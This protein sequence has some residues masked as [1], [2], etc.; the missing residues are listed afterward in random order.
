MA[1]NSKI[2]LAFC[3]D[4]IFPYSIGGIQR[5]STLLLN[6]LM[7]YDELEIHVIHPHDIFV[8]KSDKIIEHR[9][10]PLDD[11]K[12]YL[13]ECY[14][15]S[16]RV[17]E[18]INKIQPNII[19]AQGLTVWKN[20]KKHKK[21]V[22]NNPHGLES[23]QAIGLKARLV[24]KLFMWVQK[25]IFK[26]SIY[27]ASEGG[28]LSEI[29]LSLGLKEKVV[30]LPNAVNLPDRIKKEFPKKLEPIK[31]FFMARFVKNKGIDVL[32]EAIQKLNEM[33]YSSKI[34]FRLGGKGALWDSINS[35]NKFFNVVLSGYL[36]DSELEEAYLN[37]DIFLLPTLFEGMPTVVLEAMSS[38]LPCIVSDVGGV[39]ELI[40]E[41]TGY[42][43][44]R[45]SS[46][47]VV[48]ALIDFYNLTD[49]SKR[50]LGTNSRKKVEN[51]FTWKKLA[52]DHMNL[53]KKI[54]SAN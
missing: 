39:P 38:G 8:F 13:L 15:Y 2:K 11:K 51:L 20:I 16:G 4:G 28:H 48:K 36:S 54:I 3:T 52:E 37:S 33:G 24:G 46:D 14:K 41:N 32:L 21:K 53:F 49:E 50:K 1:Q 34:K 25:Y 47:A 27:V 30:Y 44:E 17:D 40:D 12:N 31:V 43:I 42:L 10:A 45:N 7:Y 19:Y 5:H 29:L 6:E 22:I 26:N 23:F 9:I 35:N 18:V